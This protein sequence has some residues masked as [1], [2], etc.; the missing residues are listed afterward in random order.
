MDELSNKG[1]SAQVLQ[2]K[3]IILEPVEQIIITII[4]KVIILII[5]YVINDKVLINVIN[6]AIS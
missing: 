4:I 1:K 5:N 6:N 3:D 2:W